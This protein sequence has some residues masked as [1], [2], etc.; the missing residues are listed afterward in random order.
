VPNVDRLGIDR[1]DADKVNETLAAIE[2]HRFGFQ[3]TMR[4]V[5]IRELLRATPRAVFLI[6]Y[7]LLAATAVGCIAVFSLT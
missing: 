3:R 7:P 5:T 1:F 2:V 6:L 4:S